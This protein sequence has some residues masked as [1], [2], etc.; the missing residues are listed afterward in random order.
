M[1]PAP[2]GETKFVT[3]EINFNVDKGVDK[4]ADELAAET[5]NNWCATNRDWTYT[6]TWKNERKGD[7]EISHF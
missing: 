6:G 7:G 4:K 3:S 2:S 5:A 1:P